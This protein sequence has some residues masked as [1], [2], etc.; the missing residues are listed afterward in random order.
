[1]SIML[2]NYPQSTLQDVYKSCFQDYFGPAHIISN[3]E[4]ARRY[5]E[6]ELAHS[7]LTAPSIMSLVAGV[8]S[9]CASIFRLL[10]TASFPSTILPMPSIAAHRHKRPMCRHNGEPIGVG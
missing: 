1:M 5:I 6:Y 7:T 8:R 3:R 2:S 4:A 10:P 9:M